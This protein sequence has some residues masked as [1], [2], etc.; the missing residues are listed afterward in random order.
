MRNEIVVGLDIGT[1]YTRVTVGERGANKLPRL[2]ATVKKDSRGLRRG[3]VVNFDEAVEAVRATLQEAEKVAKLKLRS[4]VLGI[5]GVPLMGK[6]G[7]GQIIVGRPD[8]EIN[9]GDVTRAIEASELSLTDLANRRL[10]HTIPLAFKLDGERVMGRP[11]GMKGTK[12]EVKTF[13]VTCLTQPLN[14]LV[15]VVERAGY[16]VDDIV[17]SPLAAG[18]VALTPSQKAVGAA[19]VN[20]GSHTTSI[21]IFEDGL[22]IGLQVFPVGSADIT[23]DIA[24]GLRLPPEEAERVKLGIEPMLTAKKKLD[25]IIEARL[26]DMFEL[27]ESQLKKLGRNG[28]LPA[29]VIITG[30]GSNLDN[31][32]KLAKDALRLPARVLTLGNESP[33][34]D[35]GYLV[36]YGLTIFGTDQETAGGLSRGI[37][38]IITRKFTA[39]LKE[40]WP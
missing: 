40:L 30:G 3:Y 27:I 10:I 22:P 7:E 38:G 16:L 31:I 1:A 15:K 13:F 8:L 23:N 33:L 24:L 34:K 20:I 26:S 29:G 28:L 36:A 25:E 39:W 6:I 19:L 5:G 11:E 37:V 18:L 9:E 35:P 2:L 21:A 4:V 12:L 17:A 32:D 14:N